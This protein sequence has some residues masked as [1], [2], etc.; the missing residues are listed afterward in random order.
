WPSR[1][2]EPRLKFRRPRR[3]PTSCPSSRPRPRTPTTR[4]TS[5][6]GEDLMGPPLGTLVYL[7]LGTA[8][9]D[10]DCAYYANVLGP[11]RV[12]ACRACGARVAAFRVGEGPLLLLA[13]PRPAPSCLPVVAVPDLEVA[14]AELQARG[15][16][17][18]GEVIQVPNGTCCRF[19]DPSGNPFALLQ[20]DRP[21][22]MERAYADPD[23]AHAIRV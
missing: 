2:G 12:W 22:A 14:A 4:G 7:Y 16:S 11:Q 15:W 18:Q 1:A 9:F 19:A 3:K 8:D 10:R 13:D 21:E 6:S 20:N 23:N 5:R 17:N